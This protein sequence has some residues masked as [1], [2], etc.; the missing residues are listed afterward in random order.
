MQNKSPF[1]PTWS[2]IPTM[3][4]LGAILLV[5]V[6]ILVGAAVDLGEAGEIAILAIILVGLLAGLAVYSHGSE[7]ALRVSWVLV[8]GITLVGIALARSFFDPSWARG[9]L[10]GG[11]QGL[12]AV[13]AIVALRRSRQERRAKNDSLEDRVQ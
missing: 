3:V 2:E 1:T 5:T 11:P 9:V 12:I 4:A 7:D 10:L 13:M 8:L 6:N